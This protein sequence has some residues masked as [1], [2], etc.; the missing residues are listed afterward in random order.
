MTLHIEEPIVE[1][2]FPQWVRSVILKKTVCFKKVSN[3]V[4]VLWPC[5]QKNV[6]LRLRVNTLC[7]VYIWCTLIISHTR[8]IFPSG[9][10]WANSTHVL[11]SCKNRIELVSVLS[12][13]N[14]SSSFA[15]SGQA[16]VDV[17]SLGGTHTLPVGIAIARSCVVN[18][19]LE[20]A[21]SY[22]SSDA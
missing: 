1:Y 19:C 7:N 9:I 21:H 18:N 12:P 15:T 14:P 10:A 2:G 4:L 8:P 16:S 20:R 3:I 17:E 6:D 5:K 22:A 13:L 11:Y